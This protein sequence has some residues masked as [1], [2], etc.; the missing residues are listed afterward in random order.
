[1]AFV[2]EF[3]SFSTDSFSQLLKIQCR[4]SKHDLITSMAVVKTPKRSHIFEILHWHKITFCL[5]CLWSSYG[6]PI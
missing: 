6:I 3:I 5:C 4:N 1:V 2:C